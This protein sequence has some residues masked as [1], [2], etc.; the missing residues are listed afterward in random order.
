MK[1]NPRGKTLLI[2]DKLNVML[3]LPAL[4]YLNNTSG[5]GLSDTTNMNNLM[6]PKKYN[7]YT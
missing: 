7:N 6:S 5:G 4:D 2:Y 1:W 3:A